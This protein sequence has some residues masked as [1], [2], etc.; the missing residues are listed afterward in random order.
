MTPI[1]SFLVKEDHI[2][3]QIIL[4]LLESSFFIDPPYTVYPLALFPQNSPLV[5]TGSDTTVQV[6][7]HSVCVYLLALFP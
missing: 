2:L 1:Y 3:G 5:L 6:L 7:D 4:V